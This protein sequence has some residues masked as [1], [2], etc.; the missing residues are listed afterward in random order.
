MLCPTGQ[1][2]HC[3]PW[4]HSLCC[5]QLD[6]GLTVFPGHTSYVVSNWTEVSLYS[7]DTQLMLCPTGQWSDCI[8]WTH[9]LCCVQLDSGLTVFPGHTAYV[10][11]N[12]TEVCLYSLDTQLMLCP[13]GQ[14]SD[15]IPWTH[16]LC[17]VQLDSGLT[18][19]PGH[20]AYV[21]SNW[22]VV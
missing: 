15:C 17:C 11:S 3:I 5:V 4:T 22:T 13:T 19:F 9:S 7:L 20:T 12:W 21:V 18:V 2:S 16:S 1:R 8:P 14:W 6:R 10:V